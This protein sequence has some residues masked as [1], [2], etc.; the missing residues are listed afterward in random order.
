ELI[1]K[2]IVLLTVGIFVINALLGHPLLESVLFALAIAVG[3]TPE[4]LPIIV[5]VSLSHGAGKLAKK[6]VVVK[7]LLSLEN[8][9]NMDIL[10]TDKTGTLTEGKIDV[11]S[12]TNMKDAK[13]PS[14]L[15][16]SLLCNSAIH[17]HKVLGNAIDVA[18]W[19]YANAHS[20]KP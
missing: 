1:V 8:F 20:I 3:L 17:S 14:V 5:T 10:C 9:G 11:V 12:Y 6:H 2:V 13:D 19:E 16:A 7:R 4:L 18:L 15:E